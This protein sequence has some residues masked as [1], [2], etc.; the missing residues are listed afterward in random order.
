MESRGRVHG[1]RGGGRKLTAGGATGAEATGRRFPGAASNVWRI[2]RLAVASTLDDPA[3]TSGRDGARFGFMKPVRWGEFVWGDKNVYWGSPSYRLEFGD[4]GYQ[5]PDSPAPPP[6]TPKKKRKYMASNPTPTRYDEL[7]AG[8]EDL[9]DG[10]FKH[11]LALDLKD[12]S[13][14]VVRADLDALIASNDDLSAAEGA[15]PAL[16]TALQVADSN[17][18]GFIGA[19][20][21]V[22]SISLGNDWSDAWEATGLPD[23]RVGIPATQDARFTALNGLK[24]YFTKNPTMEVSTTVLTVTAALAGALWTAVRDARLAVKAGQTNTKNKL[25]AKDAALATFRTRYRSVI[26]DLEGKLGDDD[27]RWYDFGLLRPA[28]PALPGT[29]FSVEASAI[30]GGRL[31]VQLAGSRRANSFNYYRK[32]L[33]TDPD[34]VKAANSEGTQQVIEGLTVGATVEVTVTGVNDAGE[35]RPSDKVT[36]VVT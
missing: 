12:N 4:P 33:G 32:I 9:Y 13:P 7:V 36:V 14:V 17:A 10:L 27:P 22:L 34:P 2:E 1:G 28:D 21:K 18:K 30:G 11:A 15:Q 16:Y 3:G 31:L 26:D 19:V 35:G 8:G 5:P 24:A 25:M 6:S 23:N 20:V 29:P